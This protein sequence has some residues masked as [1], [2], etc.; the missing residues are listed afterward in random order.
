[1]ITA[2]DITMVMVMVM[3][4]EPV[5]LAVAPAYPLRAIPRIRNE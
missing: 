5:V 4:R 2:M 3:V 1:M